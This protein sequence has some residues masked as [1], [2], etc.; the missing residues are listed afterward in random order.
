MSTVNRDSPSEV[1]PDAEHPR[2][3]HAVD[4]AIDQLAA[5]LAEIAIDAANNKDKPAAA[6]IAEEGGKRTDN[7]ED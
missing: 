1:K 5:V 7:P 6:Q 3:A 4:R 2:D